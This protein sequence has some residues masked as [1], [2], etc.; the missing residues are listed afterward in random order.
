MARVYFMDIMGF[1]LTCHHFHLLI[2]TRPEEEVAD[3]EVRARFEVFHGDDRKSQEG[4]IPCLRT[5]WRSLSEFMREM[6]RHFTRFS[7]KRHGRRGYLWGTGT[8]V[9]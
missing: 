3:E 1:C 5:G 6:Q 9:C 8:R 2:R 7:N 4:Q